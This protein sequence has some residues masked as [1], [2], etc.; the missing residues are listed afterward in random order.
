MARSAAELRQQN[1]ELREQLAEATRERDMLVLT[2]GSLREVVAVRQQHAGDSCPFCATRYGH[3]PSCYLD[4]MAG[5][6]ILHEYEE[7]ERQRDALFDLVQRYRAAKITP[8]S[9]PAAEGA[10]IPS[11]RSYGSRLRRRVD[12]GRPRV[13][14]DSA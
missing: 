2:L 14:P 4:T 9:A 12:G 1:K 3:S 8:P 5:K 6:M 13:A 10:P 11:P 7:I